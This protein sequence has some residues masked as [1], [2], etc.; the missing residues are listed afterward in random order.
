MVFDVFIHWRFIQPWTVENIKSIK[1]KSVIA[2]KNIQCPFKIIENSEVK[3]PIFVSFWLS[4]V[5]FNQRKIEYEIHIFYDLRW[6]L[7]SDKG[8]SS[9]ENSKIA[10]T[11]RTRALGNVFKQLRLDCTWLKHV[12]MNYRALYLCITKK[13]LLHSSNS[14]TKPNTFFFLFAV[15]WNL[16]LCIKFRS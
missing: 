1:M 4:F 3:M 2:I 11:L 5:F 9:I 6:I 12:I 10:F 13:K 14:N 8:I 16:H 15:I 7:K